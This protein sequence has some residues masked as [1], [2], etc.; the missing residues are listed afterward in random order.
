MTAGWTSVHAHEV[1]VGSLGG[2]A[3]YV[4]RFVDVLSAVLEFFVEVAGFQ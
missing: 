3:H 1:T 4:V 2:A